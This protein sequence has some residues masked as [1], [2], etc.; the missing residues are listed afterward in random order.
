M[1]FQDFSGLEKWQPQE[2]KKENFD[3]NKVRLMQKGPSNFHAN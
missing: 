2:P 3:A 1:K